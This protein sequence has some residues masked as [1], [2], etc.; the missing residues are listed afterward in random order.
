L[1][2]SDLVRTLA[3]PCGVIAVAPVE[4]VV[5]HDFASREEL[6]M[7]STDAQVC[8][9]FMPQP[10]LGRDDVKRLAHPRPTDRRHDRNR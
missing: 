1:L 9:F 4:S 6:D 5:D 3:G 8:D 10:I 7:G 2:P